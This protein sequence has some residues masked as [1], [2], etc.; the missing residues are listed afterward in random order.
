MAD[1][2]LLLALTKQADVEGTLAALQAELPEVRAALKASQAAERVAQTVLE[3]K[4]KE[5]RELKK[6]ASIAI[7]GLPSSSSCLEEEQNVHRTTEP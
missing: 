3:G 6:Q 1:A 2:C 5:I 4:D 7:V